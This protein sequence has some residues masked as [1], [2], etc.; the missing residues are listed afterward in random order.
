MLF[1]WCLEPGSNRHATFAARDFK[2]R[3]STN[4]TI[5]AAEPTILAFLAAFSGQWATTARYNCDSMGKRLI[6]QV[7]LRSA[8]LVSGSRSQVLPFW[9]S[10]HCK[11][12]LGARLTL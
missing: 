6:S 5:E 1:S 9:L 3:V 10:N 4:F 7:R 2:S 11:L 8:Q 12:S